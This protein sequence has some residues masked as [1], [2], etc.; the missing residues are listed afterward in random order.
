MEEDSIE[1]KGPQYTVVFE[2]TGEGGGGGG[3][4]DDNDHFKILQK[5]LEQHTR[6]ARSQG[7]TENSYTGHSTRTAA[8]ANVEAQRSLI[9]KTA[10]CAPLTVRAE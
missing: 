3:D 7:T 8:S 5:I 9:L 10:L 4:D 6:Q 1:H 2:E